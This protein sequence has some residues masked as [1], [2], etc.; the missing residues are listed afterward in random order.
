MEIISTYSCGVER[1]GIKMEWCEKIYGG[2]RASEVFHRVERVT[3]VL[4]LLVLAVIGIEDGD[5]DNSK[6]KQDEDCLYLL[7][8]ALKTGMPEVQN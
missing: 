5:A 4:I 3:A 7:L 1:K 2:W 8:S 6:Y